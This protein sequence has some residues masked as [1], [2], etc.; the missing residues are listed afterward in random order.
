MPQ[1]V[2]LSNKLPDACSTNGGEGASHFSSPHMRSLY[3]I[4]IQRE[5]T[6]DPCGQNLHSHV[7]TKNGA[8]VVL[9]IH[10][11]EQD[12]RKKRFYLWIIMRRGGST[13]KNA[14][15]ILQSGNIQVLALELLICDRG[16]CGEHTQS[17][18]SRDELRHDPVQLRFEMREN[19]QWTVQRGGCRTT[20]LVMTWEQGLWSLLMVPL[21]W[22]RV[23]LRMS[24]TSFMPVL[25]RRI[26]HYES[27]QTQF[28]FH[29]S[30]SSSPRS[31]WLYGGFVKAFYV[32]GWSCGW[33]FLFNIQSLQK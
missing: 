30:S 3:Y 7:I 9:N 2:G 17:G 14:M 33:I 13:I 10:G 32:Q 21:I 26:V 16:S 22:L 11:D 15:A 29:F 12:G 31:S 20:A 25:M 19:G 1:L 6:S 5:R 18:C 4:H 8:C 27:E 24:Q 28:F 23:C